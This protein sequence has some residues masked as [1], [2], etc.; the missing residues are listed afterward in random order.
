MRSPGEMVSA[1]PYLLGFVPT[2]S[3]VIVVLD[4]K[5]IALTAR[6]DLA[7]LHDADCI[8]QI[9]EAAGH[10][11]GTGAFLIAYGESRFDTA[12]ALARVEEPLTDAGL[13][14]RNLVSVV[15]G[16]WF[17]ERCT[18]ARCCSPGGTAVAD[19][20]MAPTTMALSTRTAGY[21]ADR[22]AVVAECRPDR[23]LLLAAIRPV[24]MPVRG[25]TTSRRSP[26]TCVPSRGGPIRLTA[27]SSPAALGCSVGR[28]VMSGMRWSPPDDRRLRSRGHRVCSTV[29]FGRS[30]A[31]DLG[32][33]G[34][35][36]YDARDRVLGGCS[37]GCATCRT[38]V[39]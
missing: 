36:S 38:T 35:C 4:D 6:V 1:V 31:G 39:R 30:R 7:D 25:R 3:L 15:D 21:R 29:S 19:H 20:D 26:R 17:H 28:C 16:R 27:V 23:P 11:N 14:V 22:D 5:R 24:E 34:S 33:D 8:R 37:R 32:S 10:A 18:D 2:D 13:E 9:I 12:P